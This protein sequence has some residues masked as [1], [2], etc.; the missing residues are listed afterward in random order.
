MS[1]RSLR[2]LTSVPLPPP[3]AITDVPD[4]KP[5]SEQEERKEKFLEDER[6]QPLH[7]NGS[8][9]SSSFQTPLQPRSSSAHEEKR[10]PTKALLPTLTRPEYSTSPSLSSLSQLSPS[11]LRSV[12]DFTVSHS[13]LGSVRWPTPTDVTALPLDALIVFD[14]TPAGASSVEVYPDERMIPRVGEGLNKEAE[15]TLRGCWPA[16][17]K[18]GGDRDRI[19]K[20]ERKLKQTSEAA[21]AK[22]VS[23]DERTGEWTFKV[24]K[25]S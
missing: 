5:P 23:Y 3:V 9:P 4:S 25:F 12:S 18:V 17:W 24:D 8:S 7:A 10:S 6:K 20:Y 21:G 11:E 15:V 16:G 22:F 14:R 1:R 13:T 19:A 2:K